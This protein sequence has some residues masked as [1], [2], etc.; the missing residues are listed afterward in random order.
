M[1]SHGMGNAASARSSMDGGVS[2]PQV[3]ACSITSNLIGEDPLWRVEQVNHVQG[4]KSHRLYK[5]RYVV[6]ASV[7]VDT[8][9]RS[10]LF[11]LELLLSGQIRTGCHATRA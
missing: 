2:G 3:A 4:M 5:L 6:K 10:S 8:R 9:S 11:N 1:V 7:T